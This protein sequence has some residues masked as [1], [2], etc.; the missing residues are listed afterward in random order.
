[1]GAAT[2]S[3]DRGPEGR[4]G[5]EPPPEGLSES[6]TESTLS[7]EVLGTPPRPSLRLASNVLLC[8]QHW[9]PGSSS[10]PQTLME[11]GPL[12]PGPC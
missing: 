10:S 11:T 9:P 4:P 8:P 7:S 2:V 12:G 3:S 5:G 1:M 6:D